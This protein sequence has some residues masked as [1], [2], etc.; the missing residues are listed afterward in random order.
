VQALIWNKKQKSAT[1]IDRLTVTNPND[2]WVLSLAATLAIY[3][4]DFRKAS[5]IIEHLKK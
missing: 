1:K 3:K 2:N 4:S 5:R